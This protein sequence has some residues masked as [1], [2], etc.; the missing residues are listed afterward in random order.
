MS[1]ATFTVTAQNLVEGSHDE[2]AAQ[3]IVDS[4]NEKRAA[5]DPPVD[6]LPVTPFA[7][8]VTSYLT[9]LEATLDRAQISY[10]SQ[11]ATQQSNADQLGAR[12]LE[13]GETERAASLAALPPAPVEET[14]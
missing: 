4:E 8:L 9:V 3:F 2:L 14:P 7:A 11:Q 10:I 6:P 12:W 13:G 5:Q 1:H